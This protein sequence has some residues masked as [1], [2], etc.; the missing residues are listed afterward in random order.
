MADP[1]RP[2]HRP[3]TAGEMDMLRSVDGVRI[4]FDKVKVESHRWMWPFP[5]NR[6]MA[7]NG[8]MYFP[9][10]DYVD[11][12]SDLSVDLVHRSVF[13]HEG[14]HLY[15]WYILH[16]IVWLRGPFQRTYDY[17]LMAGKPWRKYGLEQMA[18]IAQD[19]WLKMNGGPTQNPAQ[20]PLSMYQDILPAQ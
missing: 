10:A 16:Q 15:Q 6:S 8:N 7:P 11:D 2:D 9:G 20:Y 4:P 18:M 3:M 12:F 14:G 19:Y 17:N 13:V 5:Q 1:T